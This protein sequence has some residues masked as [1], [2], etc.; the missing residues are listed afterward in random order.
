ML[1]GFCVTKEKKLAVL[2]KHI[3]SSSDIEK[4]NE[5]KHDNFLVFITFEFV[6]F[7]AGNFD[8]QLSCFK[9]FQVSLE[10]K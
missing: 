2:W 5:K 7:V 9:V 6:D 1:L 3:A 10:L 8:L 4:S